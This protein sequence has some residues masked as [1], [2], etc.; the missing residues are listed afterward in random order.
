MPLYMKWVEALKQWNARSN[1][2]TWCIPR[3]GSPEYLEVRELMGPQE[4]KP[5]KPR[6]PRKGKKAAA[7]EAAPVLEV[8]EVEESFER[9]PGPKGRKLPSPPVTSMTN[10]A[11]D[12]EVYRLLGLPPTKKGAEMFNEKVMPSIK[13]LKENAP[14]GM[15]QRQKHRYALEKVVEHLRRKMPR[16]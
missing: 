10:S 12:N 15:T 1:S 2:G 11:L 14:A 5:K 13:T 4:T 6:A 8:E 9:P 7:T 3:K 16:K